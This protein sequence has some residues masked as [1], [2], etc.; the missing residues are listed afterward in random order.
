MKLAGTATVNCVALTN[1]GDRLAKNSGVPLQ[2]TEEPEKNPVPLTVS[3][4]AG[5]PAVTEVGLT[6][7]ITG[8]GRLILK[9]GPGEEAPPGF[10]TVI[11]AFP[12]VAIRLAG[13]AAVN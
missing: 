11:L 9:K 8:R 2:K 6:L 12:G 13:T 7:V 5:P 3:V 10:T 1:V 4:K